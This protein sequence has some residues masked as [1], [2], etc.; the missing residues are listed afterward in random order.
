MAMHEA[1]AGTLDTV[2]EEIREIQ[3]AARK[4]TQ[5]V[6]RPTWPMIV[7]ISPK[8]WTGPKFVNGKKVEGTF[9]CAPGP[10][11]TD[12]ATNPEHLQQ[13]RT[14]VAQLSAAGAVR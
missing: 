3:E 11:I 13:L 1:M 14:V 10:P 5:P 12:P 2:I 6:E 4:S 8:G 9:T 7:L